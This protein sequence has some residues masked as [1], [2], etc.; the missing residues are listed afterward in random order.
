MTALA[1][2]K[3]SMFQVTALDIVVEFLLHI[4]GNTSPWNA[5][6]ESAI[7]TSAISSSCWLAAKCLFK[8]SKKLN[9]W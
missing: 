2:H 8:A 6:V 9:A 1:A 5:A 4:Q 3:K 7:K